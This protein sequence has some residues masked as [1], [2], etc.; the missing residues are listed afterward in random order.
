M[1]IP[2]RSR[3]HR[4]RALNIPGSPVVERH[5]HLHQP[6][7]MPASHLIAWDFAPDVLPNLVRVKK[8]TP[9]E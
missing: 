5:S 9:I 7:H 3:Q 2:Q 1:Q 6:L 8:A 4:P